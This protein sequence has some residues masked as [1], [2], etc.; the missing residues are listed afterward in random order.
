[1]GAVVIIRWLVPCIHLPRLTKPSRHA[2]IADL[3]ATASK[4][5]H[6]H[7]THIYEAGSAFSSSL[8]LHPLLPLP[9]RR[10]PISRGGR[11]THGGGR[12]G[13]SESI[14]THSICSHFRDCREGIVVIR[15]GVSGRQ[16]EVK[17]GGGGGRR[18]RTNIT[19]M[20]TG[21]QY[22]GSLPPD[23]GAVVSILCR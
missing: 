9:F 21:D 22:Q 17:G 6:I 4:T 7:H 10:G 23:D 1:M 13:G 5:K 15:R 2:D 19:T 16:R 18:R 8:V 11:R 12:E 20:R 3:I 14:H